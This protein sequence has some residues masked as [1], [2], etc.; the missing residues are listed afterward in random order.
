MRFFL[1]EG[2]RRGTKRIKSLEDQVR[3][4]RVT[5]LGASEMSAEES[6]KL[7]GVVWVGSAGTDES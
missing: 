5:A 7:V 4:L 2:A 3:M 1:C 6:L